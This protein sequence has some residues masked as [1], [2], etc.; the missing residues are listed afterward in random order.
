MKRKAVVFL[1]FGVIGIAGTVFFTVTSNKAISSTETTERKA[2]YN[3]EK[4]PRESLSEKEK[5]INKAHLERHY[6]SGVPLKSASGITSYADGKIQGYWDKMR[7]LS[8]GK[9]GY[10]YRVDGSVYDKEHDVIYAISYAGHIWKIN[11]DGDNPSQIQWEL[12]NHKQSFKTSYIEG[13]NKSDGAFRMIRSSKT[14]MQYSDDEGRTWTAASGISAMEETRE[15]VVADKLGANRI[16]SVV[17][18]SSSNLQACISLNDGVTYSPLSTNFNPAEYNVKMFK[19]LN[20]ESVFIAALSNSD[21]LLRIFECTPADSSFN[22]IATSS[23]TFFGLDRIFGTFY[24]DNFHFYVAAKNSH[25]YYSSD[26]GN[27]WELKSSTNNSDGDTNPRTVHPTKP[28]IIFQGY[29]D[30]NMSVNSGASFSNFSHLFGW[31]VHHMKMH[32]KKDGSYFHFIGLDFGCYISDEPENKDEYIQLN[33]TSPAQMCYDADHGQNY[34]SSFSSTQDRG[35]LGYETY[36]N[37]SFTTDVKTTDGLRVTIGN[38]EESVWTWMYYGSIF[39]QANFVV[40]SSDLAQINWTSNWWAAPMIPSPDKNEDAIYVAAGPKLSKFTYNSS[41]NSIIQT[42][43]Y[44]DFGEKSG[45]EITGFGYSPINTKRWYVSVKTGGFYYSVNGGQTFSQSQYTGLFPRANDQGYNYAKNQHVIKASN[46]DEKTVYCA[47]VGNL[48]MISTDGGQTFTNHSNGLNIYRIRDFDFSPD[49][50]FIFA[51]CAYGGIWVY[52]V[53]DDKWYEMIDEA[54][55]YV[56]FTDVEYMVRENTVNF[57]TFGNGIL[58]LKL[59]VKVPPVA[60]PDSLVATLDGNNRVKLSWKDNSDNEIGFIIQRLDNGTFLKIGDVSLNVTSYTDTQ[61]TEPGDYTYRVKA[62]NSTESSYFSNYSQATI[63]QEGKVSKQNWTL[64]SVDSEETSGYGAELAFDENESTMWHTQWNVTPKPDYPHTLVIDMHNT[65]TL[66]GFGYLPRQDNQWNGTIKAYEFYVSTD[67]SNWEKVASGSWDQ[68]KKNKE[69][70]FSSPVEAR[71]IKLVGLNEVNGLAFA[72]CAE[73][74]VYTQVLS[75]QLLTAPQFVQGG[76]L[77]DTEI[78]LIWLDKSSDES[79]FV[80]EQLID[81]N[82]TEIY[83]SGPNVTSYKLQNTTIN[84][85]YSFRVSAFN[86]EGSSEYSRLLTLDN[87]DAPVGVDDLTIQNDMIVVYPNPVKHQLN[88]RIDGNLKFDRWQIF[89]MSGRVIKSGNITEYISQEQ[90]NVQE[91][92]TG[93]YLLRMSGVNGTVSK[94]IIK[95]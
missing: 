72:S 48:F 59:D 65:I 95:K 94:S 6:D 13:L 75:K 9:T 22:L 61:L 91:L 63:L 81:G 28:N 60:Y 17:K 11:R 67:N 19:A 35:T 8:S 45:S 89:D 70:Y 66:Q 43:H 71:Y 5:A 23:T 36:S 49:E 24:N 7:F 62:I 44:V 85:A 2:E 93:H 56:D 37:R 68:T 42:S 52:S 31:D 92:K 57:G 18:T 54:V 20:S 10:G 50:K 86:S 3:N 73:L 21:S 26:K 15:A 88:I 1:L 51:A 25:I 33:N 76:R 58:K 40:Q 39:R 47:G 41:D 32:Q 82:F 83:T 64:V 78:E 46:I 77:S 69:V 79:G 16:F 14:G 55:P 74:S 34:Y 84:T 87:I 90:I 27:N 12:M 53:D 29:L 30:V 4:R 38:N 80:V